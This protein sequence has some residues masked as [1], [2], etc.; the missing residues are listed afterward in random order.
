MSQN[1]SQNQKNR[2]YS[3]ALRMLMRREHSQLELLT[4]LQAKGFDISAINDSLLILIEQNYQSDERFS[5]A[6]ILMRHNQG[7]GPLKIV[8][9]LKQR[10]INKFN[11]DIFDWFKLAKEV[12]NKKFGDTPPQD[13]NDQAKQKRFLQSRGFGF[14]EINQAF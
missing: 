1:Q 11:L 5:E 7:K 4:K 10:G 14:D 3:A 9:E 2:C 6:F 8:S 13:F 12:R